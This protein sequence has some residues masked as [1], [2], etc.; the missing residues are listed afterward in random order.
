MPILTAFQALIALTGNYAFFN[1]LTAMLNLGLV[2]LPLWGD[3]VRGDH[4]A[5]QTMAAILETVAAAPI[6]ILGVADLAG[7]LRPDGRRPEWVQRLADVRGAISCR[8]LVRTLL[9][10][11]HR[12]GPRS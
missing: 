12:R 4:Q 2:E 5:R 6:L 1:W 3:L 11:D 7:R 8:E 10:D 9:G